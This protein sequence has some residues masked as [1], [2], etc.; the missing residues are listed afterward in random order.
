M[1]RVILSGYSGKMGKAIFNLT[2]QQFDIKV[3]AGISKIAGSDAT[4]PLYN[5]ALECNIEADVIVDFSTPEALEG[6]INLAREKT[7]PLVVGTTGLSFSQL[8]ALEQLSEQVPV[9][10]SANMSIGFNVLIDLVKQAAK[11][12]EERYDIEI[13][14]KHHNTKI[15]APSGS[16]LM[17]ADA[18][19]DVLSEKKNYMFERHSVRA[20][21]SNKEIGIH[22]VRGGNIVCEHTVLFAGQDE[23]LEI[24]HRSQSKDI[25]AC[26][27]LQ[28]TRFVT[29]CEPGLYKMQDLI[30]YLSKRHRT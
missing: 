18:I 30:A 26:G 11:A 16:A 22:T 19:N 3:V 15:D 13:I 9:F 4:I 24:L 25:F 27:A 5:Y 20:Q 6:V 29:R 12:L 1:R 28:A 23:C 7:L 14:E 21:R 8:K 17:I 10:Q 2:E